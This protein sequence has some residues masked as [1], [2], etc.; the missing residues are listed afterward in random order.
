MAKKFLT[1]DN[2]IGTYG[3]SKQWMNAMLKDSP[4]DEIELRISSLGG[5]VDHAIAIH[6]ALA[7]HGSV[8]AVL[9]GMVA[10]SATILAL[11]AKKTLMSDNSM[12]LIHKAMKWVDIFDTLNEDDLDSLISRLE[13]DKEDVAKTTLVIARMYATKSGKPVRDILDLMKQQTWLSAQ[14]AKDWGFVD[15]TFTPGK[16][17]AFQLDRSIVA[18]IQANGYPI[19]PQPEIQSPVSAVDEDSLFAKLFSK[20]SAALKPR[21]ISMKKQFLHLNR[22]LK[23]D[24]LEATDEGVFLN[25]DQLQSLEQELELMPQLSAESTAAENS[26]NDALNALNEIGTDV[27]EAASINEKVTAIKA[28]LAQKPGCSPSALK[29]NTSISKVTDGVDWNLL[30]SLPHMQNLD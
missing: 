26:L 27:S 8:T 9:S 24:H 2:F 30:N 25:E 13:K 12:Y 28:M 29:A 15:E 18:M 11:G 5:S 16:T 14:E 20:L 17:A 23:V 19:P 6:D 22:V 4:D 1:I 10:S 21:Q 7:T 3:Y